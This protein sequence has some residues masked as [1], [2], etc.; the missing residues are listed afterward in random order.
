MRWEL[1]ADL[2]EEKFGRS[3]LLVL[4]NAVRMIEGN[5]QGA[6]AAHTFVALAAQLF[7]LSI[8]NT[9][10]EGCYCFLQ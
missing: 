6:T 4:N 7:L 3:L 5:L 10:Q 2:E 9:V 1:H 8:C